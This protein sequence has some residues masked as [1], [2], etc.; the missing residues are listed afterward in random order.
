MDIPVGS[1]STRDGP[2]P[3]PPNSTLKAINNLSPQAIEELGLDMTFY[4]RTW[5]FANHF[6]W[7]K[8][9]W[10]RLRVSYAGLRASTETTMWVHVYSQSLFTSHNR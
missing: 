5:E 4:G 7:Q 10:K 3:L 2:C 1:Q 8:M 9:M 6:C